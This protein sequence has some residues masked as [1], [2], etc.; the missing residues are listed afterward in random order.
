MN[1]FEA[2]FLGIV[3]GLTEFLPVS[4][5]GH[6][7]LFQQIF[8]VECDVMMFDILLHVGTLFAVVIVLWSE[9]VKILRKPF[10]KLTGMLVVATIPA[11]LVTLL[12]ED[13]ITAAFEGA[14][15]GFGFLLTSV[16]LVLSEFLSARA[17]EKQAANMTYPRAIG[18]GCMQ[19]L[20]IMPG[21][22]R[23]GSTIAGSLMTGVSREE[24]ANFSFLMSIPI[25]LGSVVFE[26]YGMLKDGIAFDSSLILP[27]VVGTLFAAASGFFA[28]KFMLNLIKKHRL[29]G[30]AI[31]TAA[32]GT[33][34]LVDQFL[35]HL[36]F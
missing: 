9:I 18:V 4:S 5:S 1:I 32:L 25:I 31:Y 24:A 17:K 11:V 19:A 15:L 10:Q 36:V 27:S 14:L 16:V 7:V 8:G 12:F 21:L 2:I 3:Q 33:L 28:V 26:G 13:F 22:S 34:V 23:S 29:F 30:F 20:A 35:L 6:L